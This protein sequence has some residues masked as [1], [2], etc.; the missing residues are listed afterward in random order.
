[1]DWSRLRENTKWFNGTAPEATA[2]LGEEGVAMILDHLRKV[3]A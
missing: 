3:L 1:V 2:A